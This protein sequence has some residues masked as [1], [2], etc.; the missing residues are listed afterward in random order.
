MLQARRIPINTFLL[1]RP[2]HLLKEMEQSSCSAI[3]R[4]KPL[5]LSWFNYCALFLPDVIL[6]EGYKQEDFPKVIL[7]K[8]ESDLLLL[9]RLTNVKA[10]VAWPKCLERTRIH[11]S[12]PVFPLDSDQFMTWFFRTNMKE[13]TM[14]IQF[15]IE[16]RR[17]MI[18]SIQ[19]YVY[20]EQG[21]EIGEI[22]AENH[23]Q[24]IFEN[25][26]PFIYNEGIKDAKKSHGGQ[27]RKYRRRFVFIGTPH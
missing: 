19:E 18:E 22:A 23:L 3:S 10:A 8:E 4:G 16:K 9:E 20:Q 17:K 13:G 24:F 5:S 25:I 21:K 12:I 11:A 26:A 7:I 1:G 14:F 27:I 2:L 6:I 15:P